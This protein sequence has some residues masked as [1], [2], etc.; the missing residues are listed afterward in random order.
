VK[1]KQKLTPRGPATALVLTNAQVEELGG[2]KRAAVVVTIGRNTA[3]LRL[4]VMGNQ[5][6]IG[7][8]KANREALGVEIGQTVTATVELDGGARTVELPDDAAKALAKAGLRTTRSRSATGRSTSA[9]SRKPRSPRPDS[10]GSR[11][12]SGSSADLAM[13]NV[14]RR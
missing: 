4:A 5:N 8:S 13:P 6:L 11:R 14:W 3:R 12:C 1:L 7:I 10:S 9:R 2:G